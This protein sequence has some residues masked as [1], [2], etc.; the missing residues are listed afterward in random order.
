M[1]L[2]NGRRISMM[3]PEDMESKLYEIRNQCH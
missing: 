2:M 1:A 3:I